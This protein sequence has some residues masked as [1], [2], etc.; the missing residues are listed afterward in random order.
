MELMPSCL[1]SDVIITLKNASPH[2]QTNA[3]FVKERL[4]RNM[5]FLFLFYITL[6]LVKLVF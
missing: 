3:K 4:D 1:L 5:H 6:A 2:I